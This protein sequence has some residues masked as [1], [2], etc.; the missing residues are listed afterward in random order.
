MERKVSDALTP[1]FSIFHVG[2]HWGENIFQAFFTSLDITHGTQAGTSQKL[3][4]RYTA[5]DVVKHTPQTHTTP[6]HTKNRTQTQHTGHTPC[7]ARMAWNDFTSWCLEKR[8]CVRENTL[9]FPSINNMQLLILPHTFSFVTYLSVKL[10]VQSM[11]WEAGPLPWHHFALV[12][13]C[14]LFLLN[15][16]SFSVRLC[17]EF[18]SL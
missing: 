13:L 6:V 15:F 2:P 11:V 18:Q 1:R 10:K 3:P 8:H 4:P 16:Y 9:I 5:T 14:P 12:G 17:P 7:T